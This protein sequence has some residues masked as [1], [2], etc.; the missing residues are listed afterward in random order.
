[1]HLA[2]VWQLDSFSSKNLIQH[3][4]EQVVEKKPTCTASPFIKTDHAQPHTAG[5]PC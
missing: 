4:T 2:S 1:M 3:N 5:S